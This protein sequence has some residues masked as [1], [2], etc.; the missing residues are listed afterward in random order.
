MNFLK[1]IKIMAVGENI[2]VGYRESWSE[3]LSECYPNVK[4]SVS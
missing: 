4:C 2:S 1:I 3:I